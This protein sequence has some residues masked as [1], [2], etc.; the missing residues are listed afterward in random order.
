MFSYRLLYMDAPVLADKQKLTSLHS[1]QTL[2]AI[3][4]ICQEWWLIETDGKWESRESMLS[5][6]LV[7]HIEKEWT[8]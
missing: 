8:K 6:C 4:R 5:T 7:Y 2:D 3:S 1:V